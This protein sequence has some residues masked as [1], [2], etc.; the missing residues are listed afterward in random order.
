MTGTGDGE[1][2]L[3]GVCS[4]ELESECEGV[5]ANMSGENDRFDRNVDCADRASRC[6]TLTTLWYSANG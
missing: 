1:R 5:E 3:G 4:G 6:K 2:E